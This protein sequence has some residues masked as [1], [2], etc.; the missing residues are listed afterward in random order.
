MELHKI[1]ENIYYIGDTTNIGVIVVN[2]GNDVLIIDSGS[3]DSKGRRIL[4]TLEDNGFKIKYI[5]NTHMHADHIGGNHYIQKHRPDVNILT[6]RAELSMI[7]NPIYM[8]YFL[9]S[10]AYPIKELRHKFLLAKPSHV[11]Q[12]IDN[13]NTS[14]K[15][16]DIEINL[17]PLDGHTEYQKGILYDNV[18]FCG[19]SLISKELLEKHKIPVNVNIEKTKETLLKLQNSKYDY[20]IPSHGLY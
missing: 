5:I 18:L 2:E 8:P 3:D 9:Y 7:E 1:K 15:L 4:K 20:Y 11:T 19:D 6:T 12:I 17:I 14:I 10:G 13:E 16:D